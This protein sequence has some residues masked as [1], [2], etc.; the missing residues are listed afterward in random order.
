MF[1]LY[2]KVSNPAAATIET[3]IERR[4]AVALEVARSLRSSVPKYFEVYQGYKF[5]TVGLAMLGD[6]ENYVK[7]IEATD[8]NVVGTLF[9]QI[10]S[11]LVG[12][13]DTLVSFFFSE[14]QF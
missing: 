8:F 9:G 4:Q 12:V 7:H 14:C 6:C 11:G 3:F 13:V 2:L 1:V 10:I 5:D